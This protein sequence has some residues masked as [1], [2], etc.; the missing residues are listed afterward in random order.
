MMLNVLT[1]TMG[2]GGSLMGQS[3]T[4]VVIMEYHHHH[5]HTKTIV[6]CTF[7]QEQWTYLNLIYRATTQAGIWGWGLPRGQLMGG[8]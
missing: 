7:E 2:W 4:Y 8:G 3:G 6:K 1:E 5:F